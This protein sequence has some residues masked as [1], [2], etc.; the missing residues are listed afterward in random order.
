[1]AKGPPALPHPHHHL[2][3]CGAS[4]ND[5]EPFVSENLFRRPHSIKMNAGRWTKCC[6]MGAITTTT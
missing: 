5:V 1:M 2:W 3:Q 6:D 4:L